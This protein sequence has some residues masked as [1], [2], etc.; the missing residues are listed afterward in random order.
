MAM[1]ERKK[2]IIKRLPTGVLG[3][4]AVLGG[5][6][7]EYSFNLIAGPPGA[8]KTTLVHQIMFTNALP[9]RPA[10]YFTVL[11][12][13]PLKML[14]YQ[15]QMQFF[16]PD[17]V[18]TAVRFVNLSQKLLENGLT[19][20]LRA[21]QREVEITNPGLVIV[22]SFRT[23]IGTQGT[24]EEGKKENQ[25]FTQ[26]LA[27]YLASWQTTSFLVGE[28]S[29][30]QLHDDPVLTVSDGILWLFQSI[31]RNSV[32]RKLQVIKMRGQAPMPGLHIFRITDQG[33]QVFP[34]LLSRPKQEKK[35]SYQAAP[36][37]Q[38][39]S[40]GIAGLDEMLGGGIPAGNAVLLAGPSGSGKTTLC[41]QFIA[42]GLSEGEPGVIVI[43]EEHP[44]EYQTRARALGL[45][46]IQAHHQGKL[47]VIY[48]R[49]VDLSMDETLQEIHQAVKQLEAKRVVIDSLSGFELALAPT[50]HEDFRDSL[51]R[52]VGALT[53]TGV[54]VLMSVEVAKS[55][56]KR[57]VRLLGLGSHQAV[58]C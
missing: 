42:Q 1:S 9:E 34:R 16:D 12:E 31:E 15:Q 8:G 46:L 47:Q 3:L 11:G 38:R 51:Y 18:D 20:V 40:L 6:V 22:D 27:L 58:E 36:L 17:K 54:T 23:L 13:S 28:Y 19:S 49:P 56:T 50:C 53:G 25:L 14:R 55:Y 29:E 48:L 52:M 45:D 30:A 10:L 32:V 24:L 4:D 5:G 33:L 43:F 37:S 35:Q 44:Q 26:K 7:P 21:I 2:V 41:S 39:V 57:E